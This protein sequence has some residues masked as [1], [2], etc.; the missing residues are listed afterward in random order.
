MVI[1]LIRHWPQPGRGYVV[2][3]R[4]HALPSPHDA[5]AQ[6]IAANPR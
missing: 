5:L 3:L 1:D 6:R 2:T 4:L